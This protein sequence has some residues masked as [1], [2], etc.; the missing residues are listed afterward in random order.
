M[1]YY[2]CR[3]FISLLETKLLLMVIFIVTLRE[4]DLCNKIEQAATS[5]K[6]EKKKNKK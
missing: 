2:S 6:K 3:N 5:E 4:L 1:T